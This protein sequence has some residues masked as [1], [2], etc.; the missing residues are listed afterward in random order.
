MGVRGRGAALE[1]PSGGVRPAGSTRIMPIFNDDDADQHED[2]PAGLLSPASSPGNMPPPASHYNC[3]AQQLSGGFQ[4]HNSTENKKHIFFATTIE[5]S[6][7]PRAPPPLANTTSIAHQPPP[8]S[9]NHM[10]NN[11]LLGKIMLGIKVPCFGNE[12]ILAKEGIKI[13]IVNELVVNDELGNQYLIPNKEF[14]T[15]SFIHS[16]KKV[17]MSP[18]FKD[19]FNLILASSPM[20]ARENVQ[21]HGTETN[22]TTSEDFHSPQS[23]LVPCCGGGFLWRREQMTAPGFSEE[24]SSSASSSSSSSSS[25]HFK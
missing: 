16:T 14:E 15:P 12:E 24:S 5:V 4:D 20:Y 6:F 7:A 13:Q 23:G 1:S 10:V 11:L 21:N 2:A 19:P 18:M 9:D 8:P 25:S 17:E 3:H 22:S